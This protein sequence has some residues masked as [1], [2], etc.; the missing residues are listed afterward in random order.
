MY[1]DVVCAYKPKSG[2]RR[3]N[4]NMVRVRR[5][6]PRSLPF[7][8]LGKAGN[9]R[10]VSCLAN[11]ARQK[12]SSLS[13]RGSI[14]EKSLQNTP[15]RSVSAILISFCVCAKKVDLS[16]VGRCLGPE[17]KGRHIPARL[18]KEEGSLELGQGDGVCPR[19]GIQLAEVPAG[20]YPSN[21]PMSASSNPLPKPPPPRS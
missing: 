12:G 13:K 6:H 2:F 4:L 20:R 11:H 17:A 3:S 15:V 5:R 1:L 9:P 10:F 21:L 7:G 18:P 16:I 19:S 14:A 8:K